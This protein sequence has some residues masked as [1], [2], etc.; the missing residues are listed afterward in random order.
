MSVLAVSVLA[1]GLAVADPKVAA[2]AATDGTSGAEEVNPYPELTDFSDLGADPAPSAPPAASE[3]ELE[4]PGALPRPAIGDRT[5]P[6]ASAD[7]P[8]VDFSEV[9]GLPI[10]GRTEMSTTYLRPDGSKVLKLSE[11]PINARD[12][13]GDWVDIDTS[14]ERVDDTWVVDAHPL[15]PEFSQHAD[16]PDAVTVTRAGHEV[17]FSL[18][19]ADAGRVESPFWFWD[20]WDKIAYRDVADGID[21]EYQIEPDG[22]KEELVLAAPPAAGDNSWT[23]RFDV[24]ELTPR[25]REQTNSVEFVDDADSV[26]F[27]IP[28]PIAWDSADESGDVRAERP[29]AVDL[30]E[31]AD[32]NVWLYTLTAS[33]AWLDSPDRVYPVHIDPELQAGPTS[34]F[35]YKSSGGGYSDRLLVGRNNES[36]TNRT[37]RSI[38]AVNYGN[39]PG[40]F[41]GNA[42][43]GIGFTGQEGTSTSY[44]GS[45]RHASAYSYGG[46]GTF[47]ENYT[48]GGSETWTTGDAVGQRLVER[49]AAN[50]HPSFMLTGDESATYSL[51]RVAA[52]VYISYW[53]HA[54]IS[55]RE[56][57][58]NAT[59]VSVTPTLVADHTNPGNTSQQYIFDVATDYGMTNI[60]ASSGWNPV[61]FWKVPEKILKPGTKYYWRA[62]IVDQ[63]NGLYGQS[64]FRNTG[65][66]AF[67]T[68]QVPLPAA[69]T[70]SPGTNSSGTGGLPQTVTTLTPELVAGTVTDPDTVG[71][72]PIQYRFQITTGADGK[73]GA[74]AAS[75]WLSSSGG[76]VKWTVPQGALQDGGVYTW[77]VHTKD[78]QDPNVH[79]TW[80]MRIKTDLRLGATGPSP[81]DT[82]GP[83]TVNL[84]NGNA[85]LTFS[86]PTVQ[87]VGGAMGMSFTYNSQQVQ[88]ANA[89][90]TA[91]YYDARINGVAPTTPAGYTFDPSRLLFTRND[92]SVNFDWGTGEP[93]EAVPADHFLVRWKGLIN[94]PTQYLNKPIRFGVRQDDGA[95]LRVNE[96]QLVDNWINTGPVVTWSAPKTYT[97][98][99][100]NMDFQF[101]YFENIN[102]AV[103]EAWVKIDG[104]SAAEIIPANWFTRKLEVLPAGWG[105]STPIAGASAAWVSGTVTDSVAILTD[106]TG[107]AHTYQRTATGFTPPAGEFGTVSLDANGLIVFTDESGTVFHFSKEGRVASATPAAD[108]LKPAAP[109]PVYNSRGLVTQIHDPL[110]KTG[111]T[112]GRSITFTYQNDTVN[113]AA[114]AENPADTYIIAP[115]TNMLCRITYPDGT[116]TRLRYNASAQL[117][118]ITDPGNETTTFAYDAGGKM[119]QVRD[120]TANDALAVGL[121]SSANSATQITYDA[122]RRV[123]T[124]TLP[125]PDGVT[126]SARPMKTYV[127]KVGGQ[128][129]THVQ[130]AGLSGNPAKVTYDNAWRQLTTT[131][132][133]LVTTTQQ[134]ASDE[135][136]ILST[137][138]AAGLKSTTIYDPYTDRVTDTY[139]PAPAA[140]FDAYRKP[141][142]NAATAS[143][144]NFT[145]PHTST[146]YDLDLTD[147][148]NPQPLKGLHAAYYPNKN[149]TGKPT[150]FGLGIN[151][152]N[153]GEV[154]ATWNGAAPG[155]GILGTGWSMRLTGLITFPD[156]QDPDPTSYFLRTHSDDGVRVWINDVLVINRW[157]SQVPTTTTSAA[158]TALPNETKRIRVE[159]FQ[160]TGNNELDLLWRHQDDSSFVT[161]PGVY[162]KPDYGLVGQTTVDDSTTIAEASAPSVTSRFHYEHPWLG[163]A[164]RSIVDPAGLKLTTRVDYEQ[165]GASGWLRRVGRSLPAAN[166]TDT[167]TSGMK[168]VT[169]YYGDTDKR[170]DS[171][172]GAPANTVSQ[173]GF[174]KS[175][176]APTPSTGT[177]LIREFVYDVWGRTVGTKSS[178]DAVWSCTTFDARGRVTQQTTGG[179]TTAA[180][181]TTTTTYSPTTSGLAVHQTGAAVPGSPN[182]SKISTTSDLLGRVT[183]YVDVF[184]TTTTNSYQA[185]VGRLLSSTTTPAGGAASTTQFTYDLDGKVLTYSVGG[186]TYATPGYDAAGRL[187]S[188]AYLGG[189]GLTAIAR[190]NGGR[191]VGM[192][193]SFPGDGTTVTDTVARSQSGRVVQNTHT[194]GAVS[195]QSTYGYDTAGRL[196]TANIPSHALTYSFASTGSCGQ[197]T[198][199][200]AS[201]NRTRVVDVYTAPSAASVTTTTNY[202]YD[203]AD[204]LTSTTVTNP[205]TGAHA[206]ADGLPANEIAYDVRGN[207]ITLGDM[208]FTYDAANQHKTTTYTNGTVISIARDSTGRVV[209]QTTTSSGGTASTVQYLHS[210][211][212]D[213][214]WASRAGATLTTNVA[215]PGGASVRVTG[216][217]RQ[218]SYSGILGHSLT[219]GTGGTS[220]PLRLFDPYGQPLDPTT[221]AIGT[222]TADDTGVNGDRA[223]WHQDAIKLAYTAG[224]AT[225]TEMGARLYV[226]ALGRFLEVDPVEGGVAND[227]VWPNDPINK[228]DT[229]GTMSRMLPDRGGRAISTSRPSTMT[230]D[231]WR[232]K[233]GAPFLRV[234]RNYH[235]NYK[236]DVVNITLTR[237]SS[238]NAHFKSREWSE[239]AWK[240]LVRV[241]GP[242]IDTP[243]TRQQWDC[244]VAGSWA[245]DGISADQDWNLELGRPSN[246][247]WALDAMWVGFE[248]HYDEAIYS[249]ACQW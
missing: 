105:A 11:S 138:D 79:P 97:S 136:L 100:A 4:E 68:N 193:W 24:G 18:V 234:S 205:V 157:Q 50:D 187:L 59:G 190:D 221:R 185:Q 60:V 172:C 73:S 92:A 14:L 99:N 177:A 222:T 65:I 159:Y 49:F 37:W 70:A 2:I 132:P 84:A 40:K 34:T 241:V 227:Y 236:T 46:L 204:R 56:P 54:T 38:F 214:P 160:D 85:N 220:S 28:T 93:L 32:A 181:M 189:A 150:F 23:W 231:H 80:T 201:G 178:N 47:L 13:S 134:W 21:I 230:V 173:H 200:G 229:S 198:T 219:T 175:I 6:E 30:E 55:H 81:S 77:V 125:A 51:K 117:V 194:R 82:A 66:R 124:V 10:A 5:L 39:V 196:V 176:T 27:T 20:S 155:A 88:H 127:W 29:L 131:T 168:T 213:S 242:D 103:A 142:P 137:T 244:H 206:I 43:V 167:T 218:W 42:Q 233:K 45:V 41:I 95:K 1:I 22:L 107:K 108:G 120:S 94:L 225:V 140:C 48:L 119:I 139:G 237:E 161:V 123:K 3:G 191:T 78:G 87:T 135:D 209:A 148:N 126:A 143:G 113:E 239:L 174:T 121:A 133:L 186:Q 61:T 145:P 179:L 26:V 247:D 171:V 240:E 96:E 154:K 151:G 243:G 226:A 208:T 58:T 146:Q 122:E 9:D 53:D 188:V 156:R 141:V 182:G 169:A 17:S 130:V 102:T 111:S 215:L 153:N 192:S 116:F 212:S 216:A 33:R 129:E 91:S 217:T 16:D 62:S 249:D 228:L 67:E 83:V 74:I 114:C 245:Q 101:D 25:L 72:G 109:L 110:S 31:A 184:N 197:S 118:I 98:A 158:V 8:Q 223:G 52:A 164:T 224:S 199:A 15:K 104:E 232:F 86:S 163:Q 112:Y 238:I 44:T 64:T 207:V 246:P 90:L 128:N 180:T 71:G 12:A 75:N 36:P 170:A 147:A 35:S 89:G 76:Q 195:Y 165:P 144:C 115:P 202:C 210:G 211:A 106:S 248:S 152:T 63:Y 69:S 57:A 7:A 19:G 203:K 166:T 162:L 149:L 183:Q 235:R